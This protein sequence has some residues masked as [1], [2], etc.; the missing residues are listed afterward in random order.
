[1]PVIE[2]PLLLVKNVLSS[3]AATDWPTYSGSVA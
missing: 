1:M 3:A 2:T